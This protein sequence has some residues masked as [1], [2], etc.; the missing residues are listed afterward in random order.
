MLHKLSEGT[1]GCLHVWGRH[2]RAT[3]HGRCELC[4]YVKERRRHRAC[5]ECRQL[6]DLAELLEEAE[7]AREAARAGLEMSRLCWERPLIEERESGAA[8]KFKAAMRTGER[9]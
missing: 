8:A 5:G 3:L 7:R 2:F 4:G 6:P 1:R 9:D